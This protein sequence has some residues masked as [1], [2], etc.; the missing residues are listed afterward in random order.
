M[1]GNAQT[2]THM[3]HSHTWNVYLLNM[4][5]SKFNARMGHRNRKARNLGRNDNRHESPIDVPASP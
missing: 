4:A 1:M 3:G 5:T 2:H